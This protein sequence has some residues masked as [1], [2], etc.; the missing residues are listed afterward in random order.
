MSQTKS[1]PLA[2][3]W[4]LHK[5]KEDIIFS[6]AKDIVM[7]PVGKVYHLDDDNPRINYFWIKPKKSYNSDLLR[8]HCCDYLN[9]F[10][11]FFDP[12]KE[13]FLNTCYI[14][15]LIDCYPDYN[16]SNFI[17]DINR[18]IL[19][20]SIFAKVENMVNINYGLELSYKSANNPQLQ[21]TD[22]HAKSLMKASILM[23]LCIPLITHFAYIRKISD[24]DEY[25]L[26][27]YDNILYGPHFQNID[28]VSKLYETSISNVNRN[29]KN[30]AVI[31]AKLCQ[32][33]Q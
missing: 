23:N 2:D 11:K 32:H 17:F 22:D 29:A 9:Y 10:E 12:E 14:K 16:V 31:W 6:N 33:T 28:I 5:D 15:F 26:D 3:V 8:D 1:I 21:Y 27:I 13:F 25:L 20:P 18:Y 19:Q 30:N 4:K 24:I 7:A